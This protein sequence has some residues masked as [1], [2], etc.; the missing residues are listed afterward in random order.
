MRFD[1]VPGI[2]AGAKKALAA[3]AILAV[4]GL[5]TP[6]ALA[7]VALQFTAQDVG[8]GGFVGP[9]ALTSGDSDTFTLGRFGT[10]ANPVTITA[11]A[12]DTGGMAGSSNLSTTTITLNNTAATTDTL[13][14]TITGTGFTAGVP[15]A[16]LDANY[17][18]SGTGHHTNTATDTTTSQ[19]WIDTTNTAF[20]TAN[21][22]GLFTGPPAKTTAG[23]SSY[24]FPDIGNGSG[25]SND[26]FVV[27]AGAFSFTQQ[28]AITLGGGDGAQFTIT[29]SAFPT[30]QFFVP[31]PSS[32]AIAGLG[33]LGLIGYGV[34]RRKA[35]GA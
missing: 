6:S 18:V 4:F 33:A 10:A 19:S 24:K 2:L 35:L 30:G 32:F 27:R 14:L 26:I 22:M 25:V 34:R 11:T 8:T 16:I 15:F 9:A 31:E 7:A 1:S 13:I 5:A 20:G 29:T 17:S 28:L 3:L 23:T 21:P 12:L